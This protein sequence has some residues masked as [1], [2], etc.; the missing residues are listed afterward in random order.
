VIRILHN[1]LDGDLREEILNHNYD[2]AE[3]NDL[4]DFWYNQNLS[5][6][7]FK[8]VKA[9]LRRVYDF[10]DLSDMA[11]FEMHHNYTD[12]VSHHV[13]KD[14]VLFAETGKTKHPMVS[15]VYYPLIKELNGGTFYT[16][17]LTVEPK[18]NSMIIF[19]SIL[20]HGASPVIRGE[21]VSVGINPWLNVPFGYERSK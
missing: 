19:P 4:G 7:K 5:N 20:L 9:I 12:Y 18:T 21:R 8:S 15:I 13:D 16:D 3:T 2:D 11:G 1:V 14:E 10:I 17:H 6:L